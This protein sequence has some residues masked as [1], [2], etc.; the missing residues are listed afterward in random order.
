VA[1]CR[2]GNGQVIEAWAY[3]D[4]HEL[5]E[6]AA[7]A[8]DGGQRRHELVVMSAAEHALDVNGLVHAA[9]GREN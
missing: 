2:D 9:D 7:R 8:P 4:A 1:A 6:Q 3:P 5:A